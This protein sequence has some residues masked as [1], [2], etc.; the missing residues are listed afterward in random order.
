MGAPRGWTSRSR[1]RYLVV[2]FRITRRPEYTGLIRNFKGK[3][4]V[5]VR[6]NISTFSVPYL[7]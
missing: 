2:R 1:S 6:K 3:R 5:M 4:L 7:R